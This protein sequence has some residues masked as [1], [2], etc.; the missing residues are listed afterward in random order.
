VR[1]L[2]QHGRDQVGLQVARELELIAELDLVD[3]L[4]R[5]Q[6]HEQ[7]ERAGDLD[8]EPEVMRRLRRNAEK[9]DEEPDEGDDEN[10]SPRR[11]QPSRQSVEDRAAAPDEAADARRLAGD[12]AF[13]VGEEHL[14]G[15]HPVGGIETGHIARFER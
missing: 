14:P 1:R 6:E 13:V 2:R 8:E 4:H 7:H 9:A 5:Q 3:Q 15:L 10:D 12:G 11:R